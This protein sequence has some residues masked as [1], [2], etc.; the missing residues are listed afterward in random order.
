MAKEIIINYA[1][2]TTGADISAEANGFSVTGKYAIDTATGKVASLDLN[3]RKDDRAAPYIVTL[4][5]DKDTVLI[6]AHTPSD[7]DDLVKA[8]DAAAAVKAKLEADHA[9]A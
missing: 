5:A 9:A 7:A 1:N 8:R 2:K 4:A 6:Q 3:L